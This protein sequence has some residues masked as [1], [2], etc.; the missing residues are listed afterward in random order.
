MVVRGG[1]EKRKLRRHEIAAERRLKKQGKAATPEAIRA[2][3]LKTIEEQAPTTRIIKEEVKDVEKIEPTKAP[4]V[5]RKAK[6]DAE[7][8]I[9]GPPKEELIQATVPFGA[10]KGAGLAR[11]LYKG[12]D[13]TK[14]V[15]NERVI[16]QVMRQFK[17]GRAAAEKIAKTVATS[18]PEKI[19]KLLTS[20]P[21]KVFVAGVAGTSGIVAWLASDNVLTGVTFTMRKLRDTIV[22]ET[23]RAEAM[24]EAEE[25]QSWIDTATTFV[26]VATRINPLLWP[27]RHIFMVNAEKAQFDFDL[28]KQLMETK[29]TPE[30]AAEEFWRE[31][32]AAKGRVTG[33]EPT[34]EE[35][36]AE[37]PAAEEPIRLG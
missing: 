34:P 29:L 32:A 18:T 10:A 16:Q 36:A 2:A 5:E 35:P 33:E 7:R 25:V 1:K 3:A 15:A 28:E 9:F 27:F 23:T 20:R 30:Q 11:T 6:V 14:I 24:D 19:L 17:I 22:D 13:I 21:V 37:E 4:P 31:S 26:N 12:K 8:L